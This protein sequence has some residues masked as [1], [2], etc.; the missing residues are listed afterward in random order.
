MLRGHWRTAGWGARGAESR[1][2]DWRSKDPTLSDVVIRD[3]AARRS[4]MLAALVWAV[5]G[6]VLG[7]LTMLGSPRWGLASMAGC[8]LIGAI[9]LRASRVEIRAFGGTLVVVNL[10]RTYAIQRQ[11]TSVV[12]RSPRWYS[13]NRAR[14]GLSIGSGREVPLEAVGG[15][16][17]TSDDQEADRIAAIREWIAAP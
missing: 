13:W 12:R 15:R 7:G 14:W 16:W 9:F 2:A 1:D 10:W 4:A 5:I 6:V 11:S 3:D 8:A 17:A